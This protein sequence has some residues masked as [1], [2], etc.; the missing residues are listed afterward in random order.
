MKFKQVG[1]EQGI[2]KYFKVASFLITTKQKNSEQTNIQNN[3]IW[4]ENQYIGYPVPAVAMTT[5][6]NKFWQKTTR[7]LKRYTDITWP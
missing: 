1:T 5:A 3:Q 4:L 7:A 2:Y 6:I